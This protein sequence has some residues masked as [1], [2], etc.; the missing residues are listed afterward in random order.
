MH[1][2]LFHALRPLLC[3]LIL[4]SGLAAP[5]LAQLP[6]MSGN[7]PSEQEE[8]VTDAFGRTTPRGT[9]QGYLAAMAQNDP[10]QAG[11]FLQVEPGSARAETLAEQLR[12]V[13]DRSGRLAPVSE[14][15]NT[16][17]GASGDGLEGDLDQVGII[18][19]PDGDVPLLVRRIQQD[20]HA[21]WVVADETLKALPKLA[22]QSVATLIERYTPSSLKGYELLGIPAGDWAAVPVLAFLTFLI[23]WCLAWA[24]TAFAI[25]TWLRRA[26]AETR[27]EARRVRV[28]L[29]FLFSNGLFRFACLGLGVSVI[30]RQWTFQ[31]YDIIAILSLVW[32]VFIVTSAVARRLLD[33]MTR[34]EKTSAISGTK[35]IT[36]LI[37]AVAL[38][39]GLFQI[40]D[41]LG[42]DVGTGLAALGIGGLAL[43]LGAQKTI[44]NLVG[45]VMLV[46]DQ[47]IRVG[48]LCQ[49]EGVFGTVEDI[50]IRSTRV[51]TLEHTVVTIPNGAFSSMQIE[52]FTRKERFLFHH[53][54]GV[55][56]ETT[57]EE[58]ERVRQALKAY[59]K[60]HPA[61]Q[62]DDP[63]VRFLNFGADSLTMEIFVYIETRSIPKFFDYQTELLM[64]VMN[65]VQGEGV[66]F[67]F[68]S[69][70]VY[71]SRD[72]R[73]PA[74][75]LGGKPESTARE[76]KP[77]SA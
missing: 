61:I 32:I 62:D 39:I 67:A 9:V 19:S 52:N 77:P 2:Y 63:A 3:L 27:D 69:Q 30:A 35:L 31:L 60:E 50:G 71:L 70:T 24:L 36:R 38:F 40:L 22:N 41:M 74:N 23:G 65:T 49:F 18:S 42:F 26:P 66:E 47:P 45:S 43:A 16:N 8:T 12:T 7:P 58:I 56:Y 53:Q 10:I 20:G 34:R 51:R 76:N 15:N 4:L 1:R 33:T 48:D 59:L 68:P 5:A 28:P 6:N 44:E 29:A 54:F 75:F 64:G 72:S 46:V 14:I 25:N 11:R 17:E 13:L 21:V 37:N 57:A 73:A 55:R